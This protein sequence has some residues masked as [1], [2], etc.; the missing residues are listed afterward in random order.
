MGHIKYTWYPCI[1]WPLPNKT[2]EK[3]SRN[4]G[5]AVDKQE[6]NRSPEKCRIWIAA[7]SYSQINKQRKKSQ[8]PF[9]DKR[10]PV[11]ISILGWTLLS[12]HF[13]TLPSISKTKNTFL[14]PSSPSSEKYYLWLQENWTPLWTSSTVSGDRSVP[15]ILPGDRYTTNLL[16]Q[17]PRRRNRLSFCYIDCDSESEKNLSSKLSNHSPKRVLCLYL[18]T[19]WVEWEE[20][21]H[22]YMAVASND[23]K[24]WTEQVGGW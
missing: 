11:L 21:G 8:S 20:R 14:F 10:W 15:R 17:S 18:Q 4:S 5:K 6:R 23:L 9:V 1:W 7:L 13:P 24:L 22:L 12:S 3:Y 19:S 16:A 2:K